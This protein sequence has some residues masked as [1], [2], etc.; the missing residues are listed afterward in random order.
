M[1]VGELRATQDVDLVVKIPIKY[2][3]KLSKKLAKRDILI[4]ESYVV[5]DEQEFIFD[6]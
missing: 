6:Y 4:V 2:I 1:G 5:I 3:N